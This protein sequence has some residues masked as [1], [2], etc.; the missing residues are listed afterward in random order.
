MRKIIC[1]FLAAVLFATALTGCDPYKRNQT[2]PSRPA[3]TEAAPTTTL[4]ALETLPTQTQTIPQEEHIHSYFGVP[5]NATCTDKGY[6]LHSCSC[7]D[8]FVDTETPALGHDWASWEVVQAPTETTE[9]L[10]TRSCTRCNATDSQA[11]SCLQPDHTHSYQLQVIEP[12]CTQEGYTHYSCVCGDA[13]TDLPQ[14]ALGHSFTAY[15]SNQDSTC[16]TD[17]TKTAICDRCTAS[18]TISDAGSAMGHAWGNWIVTKE[19]TATDYGVETRSCTNCGATDSRTVDPIPAVHTHSYT[20]QIIAPSCTEDGYTLYTCSC[21]DQY[22]NQTVVATGHTWG[23][24]VVTKEPTVTSEGQKT[25]SCKNC[26]STDTYVI[27]RLPAVHAH[28]YEKEKV[29]ATCIESGYVCYTC[30]CGDSYTETTT[31][32]KGHNW[33]NWYVTLDATLTTEGQRERN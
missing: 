24:W 8:A 20:A 15:I 16:T 23:E 3:P 13:Y 17:G 1:I 10:Q 22:R 11:L 2:E 18:S 19:P 6:M 7:G 14:P 30:E 28:S 31:E 12:D 32:P 26:A 21:G 25:R 29:A 27:E 5:V 4:P 33:E 9:G